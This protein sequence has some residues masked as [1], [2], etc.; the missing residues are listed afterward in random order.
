MQLQSPP[1]LQTVRTCRIAPAR[2]QGAAGAAKNQRTTSCP[3]VM[4][5]TLI[6]LY[7]PAA[8][9]RIGSCAL[10]SAGRVHSYRLPLGCAETTH[11]HPLR[12]VLCRKNRVSGHPVP[13]DRI[14]ARI[15]DTCENLPDVFSGTFEI[16]LRAPIPAR[17]RVAI[18]AGSGP[19]AR[20]GPSR[21]GGGT[22]RLAAESAW[23]PRRRQPAKVTMATL[24]ASASW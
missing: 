10:G 14:S 23:P 20:P 3:A 6:R 11:M 17:G 5:S 12:Q 4:Q 19:H 9:K 18:P 24:P 1:T 13:P 21:S 8:F 22:R 2:S 15:P 7:S 16:L